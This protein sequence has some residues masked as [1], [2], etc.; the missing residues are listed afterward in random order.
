MWPARCL[1][2]VIIPWS[3]CSCREWYNQGRRMNFIHSTRQFYLFVKST[4]G[5]YF[6]LFLG[7][8]S[9]VCD[10]SLFL[11]P[12]ILRTALALDHWKRHGLLALWL[13]VRTP[14]RRITPEKRL[15]RVCDVTESES[16]SSG[17]S[18]GGYP[19]LFTFHSAGITVV[20]LCSKGPT[21]TIRYFEGGNVC[22]VLY[23]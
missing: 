2:V 9:S 6:K 3:Y 16:W 10:C 17:L 12:R 1:D 19:S 5:T 18:V 22:C 8:E 15:R 23:Y 11:D 13:L 21:A 14:I 4:R 20:P 7:I